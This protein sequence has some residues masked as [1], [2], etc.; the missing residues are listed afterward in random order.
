M[1]NFRE[2]YLEKITQ[3]TEN[4]MKKCGYSFEKH[5]VETEDGYL[6]EMYRIPRDRSKNSSNNES[7]H[8]VLLCHAL[9]CSSASFFVPRPIAYYLVEEGFDV[10]LPNCRGTTF[11]RGHVKWD[12]DKDSKKYWEFSW[13][14]IG[15]YDIAAC[16]DYVLAK[17]G[18]KKIFTIGHSQGT[19]S[20]AVLLSE[21][22][23]YNK[24]IAIGFMLG[25][26]IIFEN[27]NSIFATKIV[28]YIIFPI[29]KMIQKFLGEMP[30]EMPA[31]CFFRVI[32]TISSWMSRFFLFLFAGHADCSQVSDL[33]FQA[34]SMSIPNSTSLY[35]FDHFIQIISNK[36]FAKY[37]HGREKNMQLYGSE[38]PPLYDLSKVTAPVV[39]FIGKNDMY[40]HSKDIDKLCTLMKNVVYVH[41]IEYDEFNHVDFIV[42]R[43]CIPLV[44]SHVVR[45][46][47]NML[48]NC[49]EE[50]L[51]PVRKLQ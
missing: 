35:Q 24:K 31:S 10:W 2:G 28:P 4:E 42:A 43:D 16:I 23:D 26:S 3:H 48:N 34:I 6:L 50:E 36:R 32:G 14:E 12:S 25:P 51:C 8:P 15:I 5:T 33:D 30:G 21:R 47:K 40:T 45:L 18:Y 9:T 27:F 20:L 1:W 22:P 11:S 38:L 46:M 19:T 44:Y 37:D 13:H 39:L 29:A 41:N 7:K 17:T 49:K